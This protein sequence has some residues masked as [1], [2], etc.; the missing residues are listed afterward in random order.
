MT[1]Q[2]KGFVILGFVDLDFNSALRLP[3]WLHH[4]L[5][6]HHRIV[7]WLREIQVCT[8]RLLLGRL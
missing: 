6:L 2:A 8:V 5:H 7:S 4:S 3:G 1:Q